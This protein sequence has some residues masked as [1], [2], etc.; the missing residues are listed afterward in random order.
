MKTFK[1]HEECATCGHP[2]SSHENN[3]GLGWCLWRNVLDRPCPCKGFT[4]E[5]K[6]K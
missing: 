5:G 3:L 4:Y 6:T 2:Y 1:K